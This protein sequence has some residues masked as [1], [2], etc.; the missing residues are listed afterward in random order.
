[1]C[2][3][4]LCLTCETHLNLHKRQQEDTR[5]SNTS[6]T[7]TAGQHSKMSMKTPYLNDVP[8]QYSTAAAALRC[9]NCSKA[10]DPVYSSH[11]KH[12]LI[13][14]YGGFQGEP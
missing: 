12:T 6:S 14:Q 13:M 8:N 11:A 2:R 9:V 1:M 10:A 7:E 4:T 3:N 5:S